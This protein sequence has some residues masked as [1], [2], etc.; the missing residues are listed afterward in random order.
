MKHFISIA[1]LLACFAVKA[2]RSYIYGVVK[3]SLSNEYL[4]GAHIQNLNAGSLTST[5]KEG[6]FRLPTKVGDTLVVSSV[7]QKTLA[8]VADS[9]WFVKSEVTFVLPLNTIYLDEVVVGEFPEYEQ[10]KEQVINTMPMDTTFHVFGVPQV[11]MDPYPQME[12]SEYLNPL[13]VFFHPISAI[14]H[15]FSGKEK[16]KRRMQTIRKRKYLV[17]KAHTNFTREWVSENTKLTGDKLTS[18]IAYCNFSDEYLATS[19]QFAIYELM[20]ELLPQF[21]E[22][23]EE[24]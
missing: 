14:H 7:G 20:M 16:E 3:D 11:V 1:I 22:E 24:G 19:S 5:N 15:S 8:W 18:F 13:F 10:F 12:K 23:Y 9:S 2:Q 4:I 17:E 21:L 6:K